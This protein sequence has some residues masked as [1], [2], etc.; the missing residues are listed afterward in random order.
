M[1][2]LHVDISR[3]AASVETLRREVV[4]RYLGGRGLCAFLLLRHHVRRDTPGTDGDPLIFAPGALTG[5]GAPSAGRFS[6][7]GRSPLTGTAFDGS[8][9]GS[10][11]V[12]LRRLGL[13]FLLL[14][15]A[16]EQ[17]GTLILGDA[18]DPVVDGALW[19][20]TVVLPGET[21]ADAGHPTRGQKDVRVMVAPAADIWGLDVP[22]AL[23]R[24]K[25]RFGRCQTA[26]TGPAGERGV[27]FAS[28]ANERGRQLGRGGLGTVMGTKRLK[29]IVLTRSERRG[30]GADAE[31]GRRVPDGRST[32]LAELAREALELLGRHPTTSFLL[33]EFGTAA[34][35]DLL[36]DAGVLPTHNFRGGPFDASVID[37][38]A[39]QESFGPGRSSCPGCPVSCGRR[40]ST[41]GQTVRGPEYQSLWALGADCG[42]ADLRA[43]VEANDACNRAGLDTITM[44]ATIACAMELTTVGALRKGPRFGDPVAVRDLIAATAERRGLGDE[45]AQGSGRLAALHG[46]P[47]LA[48]AVK[49]LEMPGLDP[50]G[51]TGQGLAFAT[52]NR[53]A[54]HQRASTV[55][56]E[57]VGSPAYLDRFATLGKASAVIELQD[58]NA[59]LD[60]LGSCSFA[61]CALTDSYLAALLSALWGKTVTVAD[62]RRAGSRIWHAEK[63][64][65]L[66]AGFSRADDTLPSRLLCEPLSDGPAAGHVVDLEPMLDEYYDRR[67]WDAAGRPSAALVSELDLDWAMSDDAV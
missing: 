65:N 45:L 25:D 6:V 57:I 36:R 9:G 59:V 15:G 58:W 63:L 20:Q 50:R 31:D 16:L 42:M 35:V 27:L 47:E 54:C 2:G 56:L 30:A 38:R 26:V 49:H 46:A 55:G 24:I 67:G 28:I 53:G 29:A 21:A 60:S 44:G 52:S 43:T 4:E 66:A 61:A 17:P 51:M 3:G 19:S 40:I 7:C 33:P 64:Y 62:L 39:L 11:G 1:V 41:G 23:A 12:A 34:Q 5:S 18:A 13:D 14:T 48:M 32:A 8:S 22:D 10:F 37:G